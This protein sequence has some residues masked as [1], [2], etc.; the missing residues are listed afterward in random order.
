MDIKSIANIDYVVGHYS[1]IFDPLPLVVDLLVI[2]RVLL[3]DLIL[4]S[5]I[6]TG[7]IIFRFPPLVWDFDTLHRKR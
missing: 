3:I 5:I 4:D 6:N 1:T 2:S 7:Y